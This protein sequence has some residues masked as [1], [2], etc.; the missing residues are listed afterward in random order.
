MEG[1]KEGISKSWTAFT[2][3]IADLGKNLVKGF[4]ENLKIKSPSKVFADEVGRW[5]PAGIAE[6]I[7]DNAYLMYDAIGDLSLNAVSVPNPLKSSLDS[8]VGS[9]GP[10]AGNQQINVYVTLEGDAKRM[11]RVMQSEATSN[12]RLTGNAG[13]VT[14]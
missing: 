14:A 8:I 13:M 10:A 7:K 2:D 3:W 9:I 1:L 12:Y 11:F 5:I 4:K 6:G